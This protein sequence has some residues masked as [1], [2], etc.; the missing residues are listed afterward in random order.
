MDNAS[1]RIIYINEYRT[2]QAGP[3]PIVPSISSEPVL[4]SRQASIDDLYDT[5]DPSGSFAT[6][7]RSRFASIATSMNAARS[8]DPVERDEAVMTLQAELPRSFAIDGWSDGALAI[9]TALHHSLR[10]KKGQALDNIQYIRVFNA[11]TTLRDAPFLRFG[12]ALD[13]IDTLQTAGL[14]TEPEEAMAL[15][16]VFND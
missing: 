10:N 4:S 11:V 6:T 7:A 2:E 1:A 8:G 12:R 16:S 13:V 15:Q 3:K 9:I 5:Q 14:E